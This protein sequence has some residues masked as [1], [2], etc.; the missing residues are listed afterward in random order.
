MG[1]FGEEKLRDACALLDDQKSVKTEADVERLRTANEIANLGLSEFLGAVAPGIS[2]VDLVAGVESAIMRQGAGHNGA[3]RVRAF[4]QVATGPQETVVGFRPMEISTSRK[5]RSGDIA[6]LELAVVA[7]G[8]WC[9]RTRPKVAGRP[10][11]RQK[12]LFGI[13]KDAQRSVIAGIREGVKTG[14]ADEIARRAIREAGLEKSFVHI[15][16]HGVGFRYHDPAPFLAPGNNMVLQAGMVHTVEPGV[17]VDGVG[18][19]RIEDNV[20]ITAAGSEVF[21]PLDSEI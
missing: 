15:T 6:L 5:M 4:A 18:G 16:G 10:T 12:T 9:D 14:D 20:V 3:K 11:D 1:V 2:G 13:V 19:I 17:Y 21:A 7:D 8:Y